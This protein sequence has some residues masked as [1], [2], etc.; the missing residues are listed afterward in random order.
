LVRQ[1]LEYI[2][3]YNKERAKPFRWTY[4]GKPLTI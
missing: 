2:E 1:L 4:T 3:N